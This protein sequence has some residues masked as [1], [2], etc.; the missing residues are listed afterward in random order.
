VIVSAR[1]SNS[2]PRSGLSTR[3][4]FLTTSG[5]VQHRLP[6][7]YLWLGEPPLPHDS[8]NDVLYFKGERTINED[9]ALRVQE[10]PPYITAAVT[11]IPNAY[12]G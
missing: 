12:G 6:A 5:S 1:I 3:R 4:L 10:Q 2:I 8:F 7:Q 11:D 9:Q